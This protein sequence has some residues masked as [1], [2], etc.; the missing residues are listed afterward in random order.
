MNPKLTFVQ[1]G[2]LLQF[3]AEIAEIAE[4]MFSENH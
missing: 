2:E 1:H 3:T 4:N